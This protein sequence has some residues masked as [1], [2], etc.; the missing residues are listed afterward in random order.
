MNTLILFI[1]THDTYMTD[2]VQ[3]T[4]LSVS[5]TYRC[6]SNSDMWQLHHW[7]HDT[8]TVTV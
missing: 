4:S 3:I 1:I 7:E 5:H 8:L 6:R 2:V